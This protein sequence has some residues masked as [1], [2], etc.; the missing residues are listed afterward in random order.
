MSQTATINMI[1]ITVSAVEQV[2]ID[3]KNGTYA[4]NIARD[5]EYY[6]WWNND[7]QFIPEGMNGDPEAFVAGLVKGLPA[8]NTLHVAFNENSFNADG[9][10]HPQFERFLAAAADQGLK[11]VMVYCSGAAQRLDNLSRATPDAVLDALSVEVA[12]RLE[13]AWTGML[14]WLDDHQEVKEATW[15]LEIMNE[16]HA[17]KLGGEMAGDAD[18]F[19]RLY[20]QHV[21]KT[22]AQ[23]DARFD[24]KILVGG[25]GWSASFNGLA[26]TELT[27]GGGLSI[28]DAIRAAVGKDLV[29]SAHLYPDWMNSL[30]NS[31][32]DFRAQLDAMYGVL[33][34]D[35]LI[36]TETNGQDMAVNDLT[37]AANYARE[38]TRVF[39]VLAER[40]IGIGWFPAVGWGES[41]LIRLGSD[42][43]ITYRHLNS[44]AHAMNGFSLGDHVARHDGAESLTAGII[45]GKVFDDAGDRIPIA[46]VGFAFGYGGDDTLAGRADAV[47]LLYGGDGADVVTG[48]D[49]GDHLFGQGGSDTLR[50]GAGRDLLFGG[51]GSDLIDG[52]AG[53]DLLAGGEG[54]D[55]FV[56]GDG[57]DAV[58]DYS[59]AQGDRLLVN[60]ALRTLREIMG[61]A[62]RFDGDGD[63][64]ADEIR[65]TVGGATILFTDLHGD[66]LFDASTRD[67]AVRGTEGADLMTLGYHD[68]HDGD[69]ITDRNDTIHALG[70]ND[71]VNA[72]RGNDSVTG[73]DGDDSLRGGHGNDSLR[74]EAGQDQL[75]G[76]DGDDDLAGGLGNDVLLGGSGND[77]LAGNEGNDRLNGGDGSDALAGGED[78]DTLIGGLGSDGLRGG[79]G[80]DRLDGDTGND[81]LAGGDGDDT[82]IGDEG[83]DSLSGDAGNDEI[84]AGSGAD[85]VGA[86]DGDDYARGGTE[87]DT[88]RGEGG[89]DTLLGDEGNDSLWG[90][91][92]DDVI[93]AGSGAD[94]VRAGDGNDYARGGTEA[95]TLWGEGGDDTLRGD[96]ANDVLH[97]DA[98]NDALNGDDGDDLL[99][100]GDG[101]DRASGGA[102]NDTLAG[103]EGGDVVTGDDGSD[104]L[105]GDGGDDSLAGG[106]GVDI[107]RAG[108]GNDFARGGTEADRLWGDGGNDTLRGDEDNDILYGDVGDDALNGDDGADL[109]WGGDGVDTLSGGAGVDTLQGGE[110]SDRL[111]GDG[112]GDLLRGDGGDDTL[113]GGDG[114]DRLHGGLG[115]DRLIGGSGADSLHADAGNDLLEGGADNDLLDSGT[116]SAVLL[117]GAGDDLLTLRLGAGA[118]HSAAGN[119]GRDSFVLTDLG[120]AAGGVRITDFD[121]AQDRLSIQGF[122]SLADAITAG[123]LKHYEVAP[124]GLMLHMSGGDRALL[125]RVTLEAFASIAGG[126]DRVSAG[127]GR[128][129]IEADAPRGGGIL[130][131]TDYAD[132]L[133]GVS[134]ADTLRGAGGDDVLNGFGGSDLLEGGAGD[135]MIWAGGGNDT[136]L[137]GDGGDWI[138]GGAQSS[139]LDGGA[140][141]DTITVDGSGGARHLLSGGEGADTFRFGSRVA[142]VAT[143]VEILD[144]EQGDVLQ[145]DGSRD[146]DA[147]LAAG[148]VRV[149]GQ[150][151]ADLVLALSLGD[152]I[153]LR[154][155]T[156]AEFDAWL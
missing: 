140:G 36:I 24:G 96:E 29:W 84:A 123:A 82:L 55:V 39:E 85:A 74:G 54:A 62:R 43:A 151:G 70:G 3:K 4:D 57:D 111:R 31:A 122:A 100:G 27:E 48:G 154:D 90:D 42:S 34:G 129:G 124:G 77:L 147:L 88:L 121:I 67:P 37:Q 30:P 63:G 120:G 130:V 8:V 116:V 13:R 10:M 153:I 38:M 16:P 109:L 98:G 71:Q 94:A 93:A 91:A 101:D 50:G 47:N 110:G 145:I 117:G 12:S 80:N 15:G 136:V 144:F 81:T 152:Q 115:S 79:A 97:G 155:T 86:G 149:V 150:S 78:N 103:G 56:L 52:G 76:D 11:V 143:T 114:N 68:L 104:S 106:T 132:K 64:V 18:A 118:W 146:M 45:Q 87:A 32:D 61:D 142:G 141:A 23:I 119:E 44:L 7:F 105:S 6:S 5:P 72:A 60:G 127:M 2:A 51:F 46:G 69:R 75:G 25:Y 131:G 99:S 20:A 107:L 135:D 112:D 40:G 22:A 133:R 113:E 65:I 59:G 108:D 1:N 35:D 139:L 128:L 125:A 102:G 95:D 33:A 137:G 148:T 58:E 134:A 66:D 17:Y 73:G 53:G 83:N 26:R 19:M 126:I 138:V 89:N 92:G 156:L 28:M 49:F 21:L 41:S 9:S 14:D